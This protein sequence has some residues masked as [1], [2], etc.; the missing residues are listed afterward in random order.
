[1]SEYAAQVARLQSELVLVKQRLKEA[2][3][4]GDLSENGAYH[5]AKFE[6]GSI[7]RQ[8]SHARDILS[9]ASVLK[10]STDSTQVQL[11]STVTI[12]SNTTSKTYTI[13]SQYEAD[14]SKN[15]LSAESPIGSALIG[16]K[17]GDQVSVTTPRGETTFRI[18]SIS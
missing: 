4:M 15:T 7:R 12:E 5:Y 6:L 13:V 8:L 11:G 2:R 9:R 14:P 3:E 10:K 17:V 1:M 18:R 16:K